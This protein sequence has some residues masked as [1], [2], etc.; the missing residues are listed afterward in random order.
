MVGNRK[1]TAVCDDIPPTGE[2]W[3]ICRRRT[4]RLER[5]ARSI[6]TTRHHPGSRADLLAPRPGRTIPAQAVGAPSEL[7]GRQLVVAVGG[8]FRTQG[9][10]VPAG[11]WPL[12]GEGTGR[13][14][15]AIGC[16]PSRIVAPAAA[17]SSR[18]FALQ[19]PVFGE[20]VQKVRRAEMHA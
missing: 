6:R 7:E 14:P 3:H 16:S 19:V 1:T 17:A 15:L 4:T 8:A 18:L 2:S 11:L 20:V 13:T 10:L 9:E 5:H 12:Q